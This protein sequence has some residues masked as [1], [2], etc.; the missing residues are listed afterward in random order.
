MQTN[1]VE[2]CCK[3][4]G[5]SFQKNFF[6]FSTAILYFEQTFFDFSRSLIK[7]RPSSLNYLLLFSVKSQKGKICIVL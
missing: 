4:I 5:L 6:S 1:I 3:L 7:S 2:I